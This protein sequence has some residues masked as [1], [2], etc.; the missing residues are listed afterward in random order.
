VLERLPG[1]PGVQAG[2][3]DTGSIAVVAVVP[4]VATTA[5]GVQPLRAT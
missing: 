3:L 4:T 1:A 2:P 5:K